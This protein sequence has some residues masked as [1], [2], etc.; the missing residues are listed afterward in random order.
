MVDLHSPDV[1]INVFFHTSEILPFALPFY[2]FDV[3]VTLEI[4]LMLSINLKPGIFCEHTSLL[5]IR[6]YISLKLV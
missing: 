1:R 6:Y 3:P 5:F 2:V 4:F